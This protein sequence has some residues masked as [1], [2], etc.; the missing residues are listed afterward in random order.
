MAK[1]DNRSD[2]VEHLQKAINH[3]MQNM[4]EAS[5][6]LKAHGDEMNA[7]DVADIRAKNE[8]REEAIEGFREE[9]QDEAKHQHRM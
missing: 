7:G 3:T 4:R 6:F 8:R 9:I 5:D 1:P 2:N